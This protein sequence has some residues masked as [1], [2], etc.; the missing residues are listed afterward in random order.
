MSEKIN[1]TASAA[2]REFVVTRIFDA[3]REQVFKAWTEAEHLAQWWGPI[4][5]TILVSK[6]DLRPEGIFHYSM[7]SP[8]GYVMWGKFVYR[9]IVTPERIVFVNSFSDDAGNLARHPMSVTWPL[10][11]LNTMTLATHEGK[12][13]LTLRGNAINATQ[14]E[15][16]T[17]EDGRTLMDLGFT[18]TLNKLADYLAKI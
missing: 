16:K 8:E 13:L 11:V 14:P 2:D 7:R 17:F 10:E 9:E 18:G 3:P 15:Q 12:T 5:F 1:D 6:L 4:G